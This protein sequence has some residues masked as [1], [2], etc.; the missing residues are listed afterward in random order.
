MMLKT[1]L[2]VSRQSQLQ[3][4]AGRLANKL[5]VADDPAEAFNLAARDSCELALFDDIFSPSD[6][7]HFIDTAGNHKLNIPVM[8]VSANDKLAHPQEQYLEAGV[9]DCVTGN[10]E[11]NQ[12]EQEIKT[13]LNQ[14]THEK[15]SN[16]KPQCFIDDTA[17]LISLAGTSE[18]MRH[19]LQITR[20]VASSRCNPILVVGETGTGKELIAQAIHSIRNTNEPFVA[21]NC[22]ALTATLLES[23]LFGHVKGSFTGADKEKTGLLELAGKGTVFLDEISE[24]PLELQAK[25]LR[26]LQEKTFR[27][28]GGT[29]TLQCDATIV[30]SSNRNL[31]KEV[32]EKNFRQDLYY[33]LNVCPIKLSP[34]RHKQR[35]QDI[36]LLAEFFLANSTVWPQK[37]KGIKSL[38]PLAIQALEK[39]DWPG[40]VRELKNVIDRA[41][42]LE[43]TDR[44]GLDSIILDKPEDDASDNQSENN[45]VSAY[46]IAAAERELIARALRETGWQKTKAA[47]MLGITRATLYAKVKQYN[48]ETA[49]S[50]D[51][52]PAESEMAV[53][54]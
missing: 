28:V 39:H 17:A 11:Y 8:I 27:K 43:K 33:R 47:A 18:S 26:F 52:E 34:L 21:V 36:R 19:T 35:N 6:I 9:L 32:N 25:L 40:N 7:R 46:S 13:K 37:S 38:T 51:Q 50:A 30:A 3:Q 54:N 16:N 44:I 48:I 24:M 49:D 41:I 2:V 31:L 1:V 12:F 45:Q 14:S 29:K 42:L 23:E 20:L 5:L 22:A 15:T 4:K 10:T 53:S